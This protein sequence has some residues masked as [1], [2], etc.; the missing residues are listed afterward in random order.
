MPN[1]SKKLLKRVLEILGSRITYTLLSVVIVTLGSY[2]AIQY[3]RGSW[4]VTNKGVM[5]NTGLLNVN[6]FPAGAQVFVDDKLIT[7]TD[8]TV[9]MEPE[10]YQ[11]KIV[12]EGY[13]PWSKVLKIQSELVTQ[14]NALLFPIAPSITPL[15]FTGISNLHPSADGQK[16]LFFT[17]QASVKTKNGFYVLDLNSNFLSLQ[18]GPKQVTDNMEELNLANAQIIWSPDSTEFMVLSDKKE[19]LVSIDKKVLLAEQKDIS[20]QKKDILAQWEEDIYLRERQFLAKFPKEILE[21]AKNSAINAYLSPD[22]KRLL[23]TAT[24][25]TTLAENIIPP[26]QAANTQAESRTL[27]PGAI[28]VYDR[29][30]DKNFKVATVAALPNLLNNLENLNIATTATKLKGTPLKETAVATTSAEKIILADDLDQ[31]T[32]KSLEASP[33]AFNRLQKE[34]NLST[35][36]SF[37]NYYT[38]V[39]SNTMQWFPDSKH[40]LFV[41][42]G[43]VKIMEYDGQNITTVYS[44]PFANDFVYPWPDGSKL[45]IKTSFSPDSPDNLYVID[46]K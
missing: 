7:A 15:T 6:S 10:T 36:L 31:S 3:A 39:K 1:K 29:E 26:V 9:Y 21:L 40:L 37:S 34:N 20:F 38:A 5:A 28:Y 19:F 8:D 30:E 43:K 27:E 44:G 42:D 4:R 2:F 11:I 25:A 12:K 35:A 18:S 13:S 22:K 17:N 32:A 23:Y 33:T 46:L 41:Q 16:V 45:I 14:T 24:A